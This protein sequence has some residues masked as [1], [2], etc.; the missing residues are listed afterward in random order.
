[1]R[2]VVGFVG[3]VCAF[4]CATTKPDEP[5]VRTA[6]PVVA[7]RPLASTPSK[8]EVE[9]ETDFPMSVEKRRHAE[10]VCAV[11][12]RETFN[13]SDCMTGQGFPNGDAAPERSTPLTDESLP[14]A[15]L[16]DDEDPSHRARPIDAAAGAGYVPS[17]GAD[18]PVG[19]PVH[20]RGYTRKNGTYVAPYTRRAPRR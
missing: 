20:V 6:P 10:K 15:Q 13:W 5:I 4:A 11:Y 2:G 18:H 8:K 9:P 17:V 3:V 19:G 7:P 12:S 16:S 14:A 1:V